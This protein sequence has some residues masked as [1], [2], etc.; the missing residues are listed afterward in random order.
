M[1]NSTRKEGLMKEEF[2]ETCLLPFGIKLIPI[3]LKDQ[4][5]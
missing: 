2:K 1:S 5:L 3:C 4:L